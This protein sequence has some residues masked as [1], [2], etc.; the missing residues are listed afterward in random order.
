MPQLQVVDLN[1]SPRTE[2]T[3]LEKTLSS[4]ANRYNENR[5]EQK[6]SDALSAI[7]EQ[8]KQDGDNLSNTIKAIQTRPGLSP[9]TRVNTINQL[10]KFQEHNTKLQSTAAK[11]VEAQTKAQ[12]AAEK[13]ATEKAEKEEKKTNQG[14]IAKDIAEQKNLSAEQAAAYAANPTLLEKVY[15][16]EGKGNQ[17]D[18]PIDADQLRRIQHVESNAEFESAPTSQKAKMLRDAGVSKENSNAVLNPYIEEDKIEAERGKVITKKTAENDVAFYQEQVEAGPRLFRTQQTIDAANA[19]NEEGATGGIW[20][21]AMQRAGLLQYTSEGFR[22][23]ASYAKE[24]VKNQNIRSIVGA[25][26]S[27]L[28]FGFFRDATISERFSRE[29]NRQIM[30]K[31][32]A[33]VR[34]EKLYSDIAKNLVEQ[35]NGKIP[36]RLQEKVNEEFAKQSPKITNE[37]KEAAADFDAIQNIPKGYVLMYDKKRR[38]L[39]VKANEVEQ[40]TRMGAS[41][42]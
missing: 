6:E 7:Y 37:I 10:L 40:A 33:A 22:E 2:I 41:L 26:I 9:T 36:P 15:P 21:Q 13:A 27:Q 8:Y 1:P 16:K 31:E 35:N 14:I 12:L 19:L 30:R 24:M 39:H 18:R 4:F 38:P 29:A 42:K 32:Q 34:Y 17:A 23:Y 11:Q 28:E 20:D 3:P 25:Q 5:K